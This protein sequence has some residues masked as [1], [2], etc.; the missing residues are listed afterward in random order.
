[1]RHLGVLLLY[2]LAVLVAML[3]KADAV[4]ETGTSTKTIGDTTSSAATH[5]DVATGRFRRL[6]ETEERALPV[7][8]GVISQSVPPTGMALIGSWFKSLGPTIKS[9]FASFA[10]Y[11]PG[12]SMV[13]HYF[14]AL[15]PK[16]LDSVRTRYWLY[17]RKTMA[18]VFKLLKLDAGLDKVAYSRRF[19]TWVEFVSSDR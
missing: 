15:S 17:Q 2:E 13:G 5:S 8:S 7:P 18:D 14:G 10:D 1:M 6:D 11:K 16:I 12:S 9:S 3:T 19:Y 4:T